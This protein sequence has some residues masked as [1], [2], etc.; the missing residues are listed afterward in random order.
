MIQETESLS[1]H[2]SV[3][4]ARRLSQCTDSTSSEVS[5]SKTDSWRS[6]GPYLRFLRSFAAL[7]WTSAA[8]PARR[9]SALACLSDALESH[10]SVQHF[11]LARGNMAE[12]LSRSPL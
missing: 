9:A 4:Q 11:I 8:E 1:H 2:I 10:F 6:P 12:E 3:M 5:A 7:G